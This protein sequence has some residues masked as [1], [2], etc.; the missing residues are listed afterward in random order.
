MILTKCN[1]LYSVKSFTSLISYIYLFLL[2]IIIEVINEGAR[3]A[4]KKQLFLP[5]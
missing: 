1:V 4:T 3:M 5:F 2:L